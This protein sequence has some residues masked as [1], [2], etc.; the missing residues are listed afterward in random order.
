VTHAPAVDLLLINPGGREAAY[1]DLAGELTAIENPIWV[2]LLATYARRRGFEVAIIDAN[3]VGLS[4]AETATR[5]AEIG[6]RLCAVV[7]YGHNP[8]ASTQVMPAARAT[9]QA[10]KLAA[11]ATPVLL[12]GGH[13]AALPHRTLREEEADFVCTGEGPVTIAELLTALRGAPPHDLGAVRGLLRKTAPAERPEDAPLCQDLDREMPGSAWDLLPMSRYRAHN[14]HC[15][16]GRARTPYAA[17]YTT[18]GCPYHCAFCCIQAPFKRGEAARGLRPEVNSYRRYS[19]RAVLA[20]IDEL[21]ERHGVRNLKI[22]DELFVLDRPHVL[23]ICSGLIERRYDLNI[24]AYARIDTV[25]DEAL[26]EQLRCAGFTWLAF[27]I[28]SGSARVRSGVDKSLEP[29]RICRTLQRVRSA[30]I[31]ILANFI[32]GLPDDDLQ[33]MKETLDLALG[34]NPEYANFN[35]AMAYPGSR[36]HETA[37]ETQLRLPDDWGG[38]SQLARDALPLSTR[39]V[40]GGEVLHYR[41]YAFERFFSSPSY[42]EM[43]RQTFGPDV[44]EELRRM[45]AHRILRDAYS[46]EPST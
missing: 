5:A 43:M 27:G 19:P 41:D 11:P 7:V 30:G 45:T 31:H 6:A 8:S 4:P 37:L 14:W 9:T 32:F 12:V 13:V 34:L 25:R 26:L 17:L 1:Q 29:D 21:V 10:L 46:A 15:F 2:G 23:A 35:C 18:L 22:A 38:Y 28:E 24:W 44:V 16:G 20:E 33:T 3:A 40:S 39:H 42:L 36:L